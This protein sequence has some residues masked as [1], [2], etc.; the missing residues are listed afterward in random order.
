MHVR[1][2]DACHTR[3]KKKNGRE[4][5]VADKGSVVP[6]S[7]VDGVPLCCNGV[8]N[9]AIDAMRKRGLPTIAKCLVFV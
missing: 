6:F 5:T 4:T 8:S 7:T 1:H 3:R 2:G 9:C